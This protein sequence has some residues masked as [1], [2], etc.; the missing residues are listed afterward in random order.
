MSARFVARN[1]NEAFFIGT[2]NIWIARI[3]ISK[4]EIRGLFGGTH[5]VC[6]LDSYFDYH[7]LLHVARFLRIYFLKMQVNHIWSEDNM[8]V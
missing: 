8:C 2:S 1:G 3:H 6:K 5:M 7:P 4:A